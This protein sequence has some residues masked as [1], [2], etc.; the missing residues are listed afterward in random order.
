MKRSYNFLAKV[1]R[2]A[3]VAIAV[4][5]LAGCG[6][7][8]LTYKPWADLSEHYDLS[9]IDISEDGYCS[10]NS[11]DLCQGL[12]PYR[13]E[14]LNDNEY[15][16]TVLGRNVLLRS[17]PRISPRT[18][19]G[20]VNTGDVISV[21]RAS[22]FMNGK[23][24]NYVQVTSGRNTG[25]FGY[26]CTDYLIEQEQ[27]R[28]LCAYVFSPQSNLS[29]YAE[30]KYLNAISDILLKLNVNA[31]RP[32]LLVNVIDAKDFGNR[33]VVA[34]EIRD[35]GFKENDTLLALVQFVH[36]ENDFVVIGVLPGRYLDDV[37]PSPNGSYTVYFR[38]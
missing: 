6:N 1:M 27:Y 30:S 13:N 14:R 10:F 2:V 24:W 12:K 37:S 19:L 22:E 35:L 32:N 28:A 17:E 38:Q 11:Y 26:I 8:G 9:K 29:A 33:V 21:L 36:G 20:S 15:V 23:F 25:R 4:F 16:A 3:V 5:A 7:S 31:Y 18:V 34:F